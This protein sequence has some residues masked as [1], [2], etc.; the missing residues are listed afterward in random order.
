MIIS[1]FILIGCTD[2]SMN[3]FILLIGCTNNSTN[4]IM[5]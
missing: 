5:Q 1:F 4:A 2:N 3:A